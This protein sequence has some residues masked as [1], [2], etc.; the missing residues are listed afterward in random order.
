MT[1]FNSFVYISRSLIARSHDVISMFNLLRNY[2]TFPQWLQHFMFLPTMYDSFNLSTFFVSTYCCLFN[3]SCVRLYL[4]VISIC[5]SLMSINFSICLCPLQPLRYYPMEQ[6]PFNSFAH[7]EM[8][9]CLFLSKS[10]SGY[11][12][13]IR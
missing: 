11:L 12:A 7:F 10:F 2:Q 13:L 1:A 9:I 4:V 5:I 8:L 3:C 6:C